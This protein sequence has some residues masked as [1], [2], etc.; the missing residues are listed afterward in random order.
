MYQVKALASATMP[1]RQGQIAGADNWTANEIDW[2]D[3]EVIHLYQDHADVF[4]IIGEINTTLTTGVAAVTGLSA[5]S[6]GDVVKQVTFTL[7]NVAQALPNA[8]QFK[9][10]KLFDFPAGRI[11]VLGVVATLAQKTTS[12][13]AGTLNAS[14]A[15]VLSLGTTTAASTTLDGTQADL[16]PSTAFTS[17]ATI[18]VAGTAVSA[19]LATAAQ[20][21]G[22][23]TAKSLFLNS[24]YVAD[25]LVDADATQSFTGTITLTYVNLGDY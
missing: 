18:N 23:T 22:T 10:T 19:A 20:F 11:N 2:V 8:D 14:S 24:A 21:D 3:D 17:S 25:G 4:T 5:V 1:K 12:A 15:G 7:T 6:I 16:L 13:L 9:G